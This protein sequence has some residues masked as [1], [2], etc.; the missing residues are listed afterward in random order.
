MTVYFLNPRDLPAIH[1]VRPKHFKAGSAPASILIQVLGL[2]IPEFLV[3]LVPI[4]VVPN[5]R[6]RR[7]T[8][9]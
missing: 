5:A 9:A 3:E 4:A 8:D 1:E 2:V 6:F 7:R